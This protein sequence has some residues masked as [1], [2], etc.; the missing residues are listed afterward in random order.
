MPDFV[1]YEGD[2]P[3]T[4]SDV[5]R[6]AR[7]R[8]EGAKQFRRRNR[9]NLWRRSERQYKGDHW[10]EGFDQDP[11]ASLI[12]VNV[13]FSTVNT[14][15]P[16]VTSNEPRFL[17]EPYSL[18][19]LVSRAR[20][21]QAWL[22]RFWRSAESGAQPALSLGVED[23]LIYGDGF[24]KM[25]YEFGDK[26][27]GPDTFADIVQI[28][29]DKVSP[30]DV[31]LDPNADGLFN[32]RY[33]FHRIFLTRAEMEADEERYGNVDLDSLPWGNVAWTSDDI[34]R[35][36]EDRTFSTSDWMVLLEYYDL[37]DETSM[38]LVDAQDTPVLRF[39]TN[40]R[41]PI[42]Q[43]P[44]YRIPNSPYHIGELEQVWPIQRELN[45]ARS[46]L[47]THRRRNVAKYFAKKDAL[48]PDGL[49]GLQ[50]P[51]VGEIIFV[52]GEGPI[53]DI[54]KPA[55]VAGLPAEAYA[56]AD[57]A[58]RDVYEITGVN[59]YQRGA[60]PEIRRTATEASIIEGASNVKTTAK[61]AG[62]ELAARAAG[63]IIL[64]IAKAVFPET[65]IDEM[66]LFL[67]GDEAQRAV[68]AVD[69]EQI[70]GMVDA[71]AA[72]ED[73][74]AA[75]QSLQSQGISQDVELRPTEEMFIGEYEVFVESNSTE[76]RNP[77]FMEQ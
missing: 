13:S 18:D 28:T 48:G 75:G 56:S 12:T 31:W 32:S 50:S 10:G 61:L 4:T 60:A 27:T 49:A 71:G 53:Q 8:I 25:S 57:Q 74:L 11:A 14:I 52:D 37:V 62:V 69:G 46:E 39:R 41:P 73:L 16:F 1:G 29:V 65:D 70:A 43:L 7:E 47:A 42:V 40:V 72:P 2:I 59:E 3:A 54:V 23:Q 38:L 55:I 9:E 67:T 76:L 15:R 19:S 66:G 24:L 26:Q 20:L 36:Q 77:I 35:N 33:V 45:M 30:W 17:V 68:R 44:N 34:A 6:F 58:L 21:Q 5:V 64:A 51:I 22:N 63:T